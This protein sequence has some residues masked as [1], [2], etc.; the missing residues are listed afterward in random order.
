[1]E[2]PRL[3]H[4]QKETIPVWGDGIKHQRP[5]F[6]LLCYIRF[7][8]HILLITGF[9]VRRDQKRG[10]CQGALDSYGRCVQCS[11]LKEHVLEIF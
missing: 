9:G 4:C 5:H 1:M 11:V 2:T 6:S 7:Q 10:S 3:L 8:H